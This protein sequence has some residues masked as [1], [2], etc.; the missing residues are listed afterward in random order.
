MAA[1]CTAATRFAVLKGGSQYGLAPCIGKAQIR[2]YI[3]V[4]VSPCSN[5]P[6]RF[7]YLKSNSER[8]SIS[9]THLGQGEGQLVDVDAQLPRRLPRPGREPLQPGRRSPTG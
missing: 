8:L 6:V 3:R 4:W 1:A 7:R 9:R 2:P 5:L